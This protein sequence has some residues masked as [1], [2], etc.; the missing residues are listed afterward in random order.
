MDDIDEDWALAK[1]R[2]DRSL[3]LAESAGAASCDRD[4][5]EIITFNITSAYVK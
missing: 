1:A 2:P 5:S 4:S 3:L